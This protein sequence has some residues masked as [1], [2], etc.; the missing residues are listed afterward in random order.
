MRAAEVC[1]RARTL[2]VAA[3]STAVAAFAPVVLATPS[4][5]PEV[6]SRRGKVIGGLGTTAPTLELTQPAGGWTAAMRIDVAGTCSDETADPIEVNI[7]GT[8]YFIRSKGG[9]FARKFP[10]APG[11]NAIAV[12]CR[13]QAGVARATSTV[14]AVISPIPLKIVLTSDTDSAYTDLHIYEPEGTHVFWASTRSPSGGI[15]FLNDEAGS[16][17]QPGYGP[18]LYVHPSAPPG[19]FRIDANYWPGGAIRHTLANLDVILNEGTPDEVRRRVRRP[20]ARPDETQTLAYVVI[21]PNHRPAE[22]FVP[23][24]DPESRLPPEVKEYREKIEPVI[25]QQSEGG[26]YAFVAPPD[27]RSLRTAVARLALA[28]ARK[29]SPRWEPQQ[30]DCA[31]LVR[32]AYREALRERSATQLTQLAMPKQLFLPAVSDRARRLLPEYP[33]IWETGFGA[34]GRE[35]WGDFAD[36]ETLVGFNFRRI[37]FDPETALPGDLLVY[38]K[39]LEADEPYHLMMLGAHAPGGDSVVVYHNGGE[40]ADGEVRVVSLRDLASA[41]DPVWIPDRRNPHFLG[42]YAW[43]K[44]RPRPLDAASGS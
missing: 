30:R 39:A 25:K 22:L 23:G 9:A 14:E 36:A 41:P 37:G 2:G 28:Q 6:L 12:E 19:V 34:G 7:N 17:D 44:L 1:L 5:T 27:E 8:R 24:Q 15:F 10:A 38:R 43:T 35:R 16:F 32:F 31:G 29:P 33:K 42:I 11:T 40:G 20:L 13:N 26:D 18:Y 3:V 21:R 4:D